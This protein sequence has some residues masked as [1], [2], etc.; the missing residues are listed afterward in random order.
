MFGNYFKRLRTGDPLLQL[1]LI[2]GILFIAVQ[3]YLVSYYLSGKPLDPFWGED[4]MLAANS[5]W[6]I[7]K[8]RPWSLVTHMFAHIH[9]GHFLFN[10]IALYSMGK[11]FLSIE[12]P[13]NLWKLYLLGGTF[14]YLL[15]AISFH[16]SNVLSGGRDHAILGA[17]AAVMAIV[18]ATAVMQPRR[19]VYLFGA[20]RLELAWLAII[21]I[22]LDLASIRQGVNSGGHIGHIGGGLFGFFYGLKLFEAGRLTAVLASWKKNLT[23][24]LRPSS[25]KVVHRRPK[26]DDEYNT[27]R[28]EKQKK[29][30]II[31]DKIGQSGYESLTQT[32]KDFLFKHSQK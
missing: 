32:E 23:T 21:L 22:V 6:E 18:V 3:V 31:L 8:Q 28:A 10:M 19:I 30:D 16:F 29:I 17:S 26:T 15:F 9:T 25:M 20:V 5:S 27:D 4:L 14:G 13:S 2:N 12:R 7:M 11:I 1:I 24:L